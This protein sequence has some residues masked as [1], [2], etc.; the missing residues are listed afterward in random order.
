MSMTLAAA[1]SAL[2]VGLLLGLLGG[3][4]SILAVPIFTYLLGFPPKQA[5][6]MSLLVVGA[7][8]LIGVVAHWRQGNVAARPAM[9]FGAAA[10]LGALAGARLAVRA[11]GAFQMILFALVVIAAAA[12]MLRGKPPRE[13]HGAAPPAAMVL[14]GLGVGALTG[15]VGVGGGFL[16]VPALVILGGLP[17]RRAVGTSLL[18]IAANSATALAGYLGQVRIDW[19][20]FISFTAVAVLG[21]VAGVRLVK[22]VPARALQRG[23]GIVLVLIGGFVLYQN[24]AAVGLAEA[25]RPAAH[26]TR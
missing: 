22:R 8:S 18:V 2:V 7:V 1:A 10:M 23:F 11:S 4:G 24:R 16:I 9:A 6:V 12:V 25:G 3:G 5:I 17:F 21:S 26:S 14:A 15:M 20:L 19:T 13:G